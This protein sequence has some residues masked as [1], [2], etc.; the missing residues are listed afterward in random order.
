MAARENGRLSTSKNGMGT[1]Y[2]HT[3]VGFVPGESPHERGGEGGLPSGDNK[4]KTIT[5]GAECGLKDGG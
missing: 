1:R 3:G 5:G 4:R 2:A